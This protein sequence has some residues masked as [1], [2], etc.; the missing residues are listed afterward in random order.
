M[1][2]VGLKTMGKVFKKKLT[3]NVEGSGTVDRVIGRSHTGRSI[4]AGEDYSL[5]QEWGTRGSMDELLSHT[6]AARFRAE[7]ASTPT[8]GGSN[9]LCVRGRDDDSK[10]TSWQNMGPEDPPERGG[11]Y[12]APGVIALYLC[13]SKDGVLRELKPIPGRR[14]FLQDY[15]I[16]LDELRLADCS[17]GDLTDFMK[18]VFDRAE[19]CSVEGHVE[20]S[21][22]MFSQV[23]GQ[24]VREAA[25]E[26]MLVPG[27]RGVPGFQ[28][29]NVVVFDTHNRWRTWS[30]QDAG[31]RYV[32]AADAAI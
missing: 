28:Y 27:V 6:A 30:R 12:N 5:A 2:R 14:V 25:F 18:A 26:G 16:P 3:G 13:D 1:L 20:S 22:Y 32:M 24:L 23:V 21:N 7:L 9:L 19:R 29:R 10:I 8:V 15:E 31:F 17:S 4:P 11:R